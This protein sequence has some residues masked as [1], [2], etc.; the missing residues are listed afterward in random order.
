MFSRTLSRKGLINVLRIWA[1]HRGTQK[2]FEKALVAMYFTTKVPNNYTT[3]S[4]SST[5]K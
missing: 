1:I 5:Q 4:L 2:L 3:K